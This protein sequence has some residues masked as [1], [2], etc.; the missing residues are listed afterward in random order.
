[1][2]NSN[3]RDSAARFRLRCVAPLWMPLVVAMSFLGA[4]PG[5]GAADGVPPAVQSLS[6]AADSVVRILGAVE[7]AFSEP[8]AGVD[9]AD[10]LINGRPATNMFEAAPGQF[11]FEFPPPAGGSVNVAWAD[12]HGIVDLAVP[13]N[14]FAGGAWSYLL[15]TNPP[16]DG[17]LIN[18]FLA[19]NGSGLRDDD[20]DNSD[21]I[22]LRNTNPVATG[23]EGWFLTD[24][25]ANLTK[26]RFPAVTMEPDSYLL[27]FA[28]DKNRATNLN[29]LHANFKLSSGG[30]FL[31][32][33][34]PLTN[35]VS[36]FAPVYPPQ[37]ED[38]SYGRNQLSPEFAGTM[39]TPTPGAPN[40]SAGPGFAPGVKFSVDGGTFVHPFEL[41]LTSPDPAAVIRYVITGN[42]AGAVTNVPTATS[43]V[44]SGPIPISG[45]TQVRARAF[46]AGYLPGP[47]HTETF[48]QLQPDA[49]N[50]SSDLP[51]VIIHNLG[52][53]AVPTSGDQAAYI[54]IFE[55]DKTTG[56]A[57][58][59]G[60]PTVEG[61]IGL[62]VRGRGSQGYA[63]S[64]LAVEFW[65][66][67]NQDKSVEVMG[68]PAESDWVFY[69]T[70]N[71]DAVQIHNPLAR[72]MSNI[73]GRPASRTRFAEVFLNT[74]GGAVRHANLTNGNYNGLY[75]VME[76][77]KRGDHRVNVASLDP[78]DS[79]P[80][81][82]TG[83]YIFKS[84]DPPEADEYT[85]I[86]AQQQVIM[87]Y[88]GKRSLLQP[89][90]SAQ[91]N[92]VRTL[93][94]N[95]GSALFG[96]N[97]ADPVLGYAGYI[98]VDSW[99]DHSIVSVT[100]FNVDAIRLSGY[101]FKDR[102]K[103]I[104]MGPVWDCD[105]SLG[106][107][108]G[109]Q[110]NPRRWR[111]DQGDGGTD[112]FN[113][114][115]PGPAHHWYG[116][117]YRDINFWQRFIDRY[118]TARTGP[119]SLTNLYS[120]IDR[121][122]AEVT[123]AQARDFAK[124]GGIAPLRNTNGTGSGTFATEVT[125]LKTWLAN[126]LDFMDTNF[127]ARPRFNAGGGVVPPGFQATLTA[128]AKPDTQ[129]YF[130]L[131]G[132]D[133]RAPSGG[134]SPSAQLYVAPLTI[135]ANTRVTARSYNTNHSNLTGPGNPPLSSPWS[136]P[137]EA[138]FVVRTPPLVITE[139]MYH[140]DN[141]PPGDPTDPD[142]FEFIELKNVVATTLSLAG[143]RFTNGIGFTFTATNA[144]TSLPPGGYVL[145]VKNRAAFAARHPG[146]TNVAGEF[147]GNLANNGNRL[148]LIGP[149]GEPMLDFT[150]KDSW[151]PATDGSGFSLV[152][153]NELA[154]AAS[155]GSNSSWRVSARWHGSPGG[156]DTAPATFAPVLV[157]EVLAHTT[158]PA[159]DA[160]ELYNPSGQAVDIS[161]WFL[162][163]DFLRPAKFR[164]PNG[165]TVPAGGYAYFTEAQF[166][167][168]N[169]PGAFALSR[170]GDEVYLFS[171]NGTEITGYFDG[172]DFGP[173]EDGVSVGRLVM[174][175]GE[176]E[177]VAQRSVTLGAANSGP[178][179][180]P[181]VIEQIAPEPSTL[182]LGLQPFEDVAQEFVV[183]RNTTG[184]NVALFDPANPSNTWKLSGGI[185]FDFPS[186]VVVP[187]N[188]A[189]AVVGFDPM[190]DA[191]QRDAFQVQSGL[192]AG[193]PLFGPFS[194]NLGN[195]DDRVILRKP[196]LPV[197]PPA[198]DAGTVPY[199]EV[200]RVEY[201]SR[202]PWPTNPVPDASSV[203]RRLSNAVYGNDPANWQRVAVERPA[204]DAWPWI[205]G[206][207]V[208]SNVVF[209][210]AAHGDGVPA[211]QWRFN[212][213][214]IP[215][216]TEAELRLRDFPTLGGG[217][218]DARVT[219]QDGSMLS[220]R[221]Y[222]VL[223]VAPSIVNQPVG[224]TDVPGALR[225]LSVS[226]TNT[227]NLPIT[228][229]WLRN[230]GFVSPLI[231]TNSHTSVIAL[232]RLLGNFAGPYSVV[233]SNS[234]MAG[235]GY[236]T[237]SI[238]PVVVVTPPSNSVAGAGTNVTFA[239]TIA[240][241][242]A[243]PVS[244]QWRFNGALLSGQTNASLTLT[245]VQ[246]AHEGIYT[247]DVRNLQ[248]N[249]ASFPAGL[250]LRKPIL[251]GD[252][253]WLAAGA[254]RMSLDAIPYQNYEVQVATNLTAGWQP[255]VTLAYTNGV[256]PIIDHSATNPSPRFY[257]ARLAP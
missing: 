208:R 46:K 36:A 225:F 10:L 140:P 154:P 55:P 65:D 235:V 4:K 155:W 251:L 253:E 75:V 113:A 219:D 200:D 134:I 56:R 97:S 101:F 18:E 180:G 234:A 157:N 218:Y 42:G 213:V 92:Y 23:L 255:L 103:R 54:A 190:L 205:Q 31:A 247:L 37:V 168:P 230:S 240:A 99:I 210:I 138:V 249:V 16:V 45:T 19:A 32:L 69:A 1:M 196:G 187:P 102:N 176:V 252:P 163:D 125:W 64:S 83:G 71:T 5:A 173:S 6:P 13:P 87:V 57:T 164:I 165:T 35:I 232:P 30:E 178:R 51:I 96:T 34:N 84:D 204:V 80:E 197:A 21:W 137:D 246:P 3:N 133:P 167:A 110:L 112:Y 239:G 185:D 108:D 194:G 116:Q 227:A 39:A 188:G 159:V 221:I 206:A 91:L 242:S 132:S 26:W 209:Q 117:L 145:I 115:G 143:I 67:L 98:D 217:W 122:I 104:E 7:I 73:L 8:V 142:A 109:R 128:P 151:H 76:K 160:I 118:Q 147:Q 82:I 74:G 158:L 52:Q 169:N 135:S 17:V 139:I 25:P 107:T 60:R 70:L 233:I 93:F 201:A 192:D 184:T 248:G 238:A 236:L 243:N 150:Y 222:L 182:L 114:P 123:E 85:F 28:S 66:E 211:Y 193:I 148:A 68:M 153:V 100:T 162:T 24:D 229:R 166:N 124:W 27:V 136:G 33:V 131:D 22:E 119:Y 94:N 61:R 40:A 58:L 63:K 212:G 15:D 105:R 12:G 181:I 144:V 245:N 41:H 53:G 90:R 11:V 86:G 126:R 48:I 174:G 189:I 203:L 9:A 111:G 79:D 250:G 127:L 130:T 199:V 171:G 78:G 220:P 72:E 146:V 257:R 89:Q 226:V 202:A 198:P 152:I 29:W 121:L 175:T 244:L 2:N 207:Q 231:V 44:Y 214:D 186:G 14:P 228:Y 47:L 62:N 141:P 49:L 172:F 106:S 177:H 156:P 170:L 88:P 81:T 38:V 215:G 223:L 237:S 216:A 161:G 241:G 20:G 50:F 195:A 256:L 254:F 77:I 149:V 179:T 120:I 43:P 129:I 191:Y 95:F 59:A 183:L 224:F